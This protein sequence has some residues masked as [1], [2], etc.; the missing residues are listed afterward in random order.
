MSEVISQ[1][2]TDV[3]EQVLAASNK[4]R[5]ET[6]RALVTVLEEMR[7]R[8]V[9]V[10]TISNVGRECEERKLL[11]TQ[12]I[13]NA[14]GEPFRRIIEAFAQRHGLATTHVPAR[15]VTPLE[16]AIQSI[17][18]LDIRHRLLALIDD[19]KA[20][21]TQVQRLENGFKRL[22]VPERR[23]APAAEPASLPAQDIEV[24]PPHK[25]KL[26][27]GPLERF[28]SEDWIDRYAWT[29]G[30]SGAIID[31]SDPITPPGFVPALSEA[32]TFLRS[33][34]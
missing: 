32:I 24:V 1:L 23:E 5:Q 8:G 22:Q 28:I 26:N 7:G 2:F 34:R 4:R 6:V 14:T 13:R 30:E 31:G 25:T 16:E 12:S 15:K 11:T 17:P 27:L 3:V 21:R 29:V 9:K 19:N 33:R 20:L 18:D 10:F